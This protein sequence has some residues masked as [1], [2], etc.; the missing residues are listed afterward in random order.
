MKPKSGWQYLRDVLRSNNISVTTFG[1]MIGHSGSQLYCYI[2]GETIPSA[3]TFKDICCGLGM[4][5]NKPWHENAR[6]ILD[7]DYE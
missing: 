6:I 5:N 3:L 4:L 7:N 1:D 2:R